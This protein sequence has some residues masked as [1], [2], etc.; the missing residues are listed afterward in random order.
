[1][2]RKSLWFSVAIL[3]AVGGGVIAG[4]VAMTQHI[5]AFYLRAAAPTGPQRS[6]LSHQFT[7]DAVDLRNRIVAG[8][9]DA[10]AWGKQFSEDELNAFFAEEFLISLAGLPSGAS[11]L[12]VEID[13]DRLRIGFRYGAEFWSTIISID[14]R[15]WL[16]KGQPNVIVLQLTG[17]HAG[18]LP[19]SSQ[20]LLEGISTSL[21]S[22]GIQVNWYRHQGY[23]T[24]VLKIQSDQSQPSAVLQRITLEPG[25]IKI[26]GQSAGPR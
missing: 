16:A 23:P 18:S 26:V 24:A 7:N 14:F 1:M 11:D 12:R 4:L 5:P 8:D 6:V 25:I 20:S 19:I 13:D 22:K 17:L 15:V 10:G 21:S 9:G 2:W 3:V